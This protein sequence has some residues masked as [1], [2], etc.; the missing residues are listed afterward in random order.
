MNN[1]LFCCGMRRK[2]TILLWLEIILTIINC[3]A[4]AFFLH[5]ILGCSL[6]FLI[7]L[8]FL[9]IAFQI[10]SHHKKS[11]ISSLILFT[12]QLISLC[13]IFLFDG[14][15]DIDQSRENSNWI[16]REEHC[17]LCYVPVFIQILI[18]F[19]TG[20]IVYFQ[21]QLWKETSFN[22]NLQR[23]PPN[24]SL[25]SISWTVEQHNQGYEPDIVKDE[26]TIVPELRTSLESDDIFKEFECPICLSVMIPPLQIYQCRFGH[27]ICS[28]CQSK[29]ITMCPS[30]RKPILGRAHNMENVAKLL[31]SEKQICDES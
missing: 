31:F 2:I 23:S 1:A 26:P 12:F 24:L 4:T 8:N 15:R 18:I 10:K 27:N 9:V 30:C 17:S 21:W 7:L 13:I 14:F 11:F 20:Y 25:P 19:L 29:G 3:L 28:N 16:L 6:S 5:L 22:G